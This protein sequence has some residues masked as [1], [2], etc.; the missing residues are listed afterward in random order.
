MSTFDSTGLT[1]DRLDDAQQKLETD[2]QDAFGENIRITPDSVFGQIIGIFAEVVS[3]QNELIETVA[4]QGNPNTAS[5]AF[6]SQLVQFNGI[7]RKEAEFSSVS[8]NCTAGATGTTIPA[9]SLVSD[10]VIGEQ[11]ATDVE[12]V[13]G[14]GATESVSATAVNSGPI[15]AAADTLT[16]I[17]TPILGWETVTNPAAA[18]AGLNEETDSELRTRRQ[19]AAAQQ[20]ASNVA[21]IFTAIAN[22]DEVADLKV[23]QNNTTGTI[24]NVPPQHIF[25]I[26]LG[27]SDADIAE[28]LFDTV[29]AG[30]GY[31]NRGVGTSVDYYLADPVT[32]DTYLIKFERPTDVTIDIDIT[33]V[34]DVA[35]YPPDGD[36]QIKAAILTYFDETQ[37]ISEDLIRSRLYTPVNT[38]PG[39]SITSIL[40]A[41]EG[42]TTAV[43]NIQI[44]TYERAVTTTTNITIVK[45]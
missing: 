43:Q 23:F 19:I 29:A 31:Y 8:L 6:L 15:E 21:A 30:I 39:H 9:G 13:V 34:V 20:G 11:F 33:L 7:Q 38:V 16:K 3:S 44:A 5:G 45:S 22:I 14:S 37:K 28:A 25:A 32:G 42:E 41:K 36:D 40:I 18:V 12:L 17:D 4:N 27:G 10:P 1:M 26:V 2:L 35:E 24:E